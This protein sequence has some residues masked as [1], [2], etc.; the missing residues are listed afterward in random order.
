MRLSDHSGLRTLKGCRF[1]LSLLLAL[2]IV[3]SAA[4][5]IRRIEISRYVQPLSVTAGAYFLQEF[6]FSGGVVPRGTAE[7]LSP[8]KVKLDAGQLKLVILDK[9]KLRN[10]RPDYDVIGIQW[11]GDVYQLLAQDD[12]IYPLMK[13]IQRGSYIAYTIPMA[14]LNKDYF[15]QNALLPV[16]KSGAYVAKEFKSVPHTEFLREVD[17][18]TDTEAM[19]P[20]LKAMIMQDVNKGNKQLAE[21]G[22]YVN[23]DFH[24]K[25]QVF[26]DNANGKKVADVGGLPLRYHWNIAIDGSAIL[27]DVE[28]FTFPEEDFD[29]QYRAVLFF[30]T[31]A[32]L[33]Q[34]SQDNRQEF[35]RFLKEV[36]DIVGEQ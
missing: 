5:G 25:Y 6:Q 18:D 12:L 36:G 30:Q 26:L 14:G 1:I 9:A 31:A 27:E 20:N 28:V 17:L 24:V 10:D 11:K 35:D 15:Q 16:P 33:R 29:L 22:S 7:F 19:P 32:I 34:L 23:A 8:A 2:L 13:F 3:S 21:E 4:A